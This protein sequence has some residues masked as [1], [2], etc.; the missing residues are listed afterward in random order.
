VLIF[1]IGIIQMTKIQLPTKTVGESITEYVN[2]KGNLSTTEKGRRFLF[3]IRENLIAE[4]SDD[5]EVWLD[6]Y[7]DGGYDLIVFAAG[8]FW[9]I[10]AKYQTSH[11]LESAKAFCNDAQR[12]RS[13]LNGKEQN[14]PT[15]AHALV[16]RV[17]SEG[18]DTAQTHLSAIYITD[19]SFT[20]YQAGILT[21]QTHNHPYIQFLDL[22]G[23]TKYLLQVTDSPSMIEYPLS[24]V[25]QPTVLGSV[26]ICVVPLVDLASFA[27]RVGIQLFAANIRAYLKRTSINKDLAATLRSK[28]DDFL[29]FNNGI[30]MIAA[31]FKVIPNPWQVRVT[32]AQVVNGCQTV[33]EI[34]NAWLSL[35][36]NKQNKNDLS[37]SV[38]VKVVKT[39]EKELIRQISRFTNRQNAVRTRDFLAM[40]DE[41]RALHKGMGKIGYYYEITRG[42]AAI[43]DQRKRSS[44]K[45]NDGYR[46]LDRKPGRFP[47]IRAFDSQQCFL[48]AYLDRP[49][50]AREKLGQLN[51]LEPEYE[52]AFRG[53]YS[54][55]PLAHLLPFLIHEAAGFHDYGSSGQGW[56][57][58]ARLWFVA[59][60]YR[61]IVTLLAEVDDRYKMEDPYLREPGVIS[62]AVAEIMT[63]QEIGEPL[64][65]LADEIAISFNALYKTTSGEN[66]HEKNSYRKDEHH[67]NLRL[68]DA[69]H[70]IVVDHV[71]KRGVYVIQNK[72]KAIVNAN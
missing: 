65:S 68:L 19:S 6:G 56:K 17:R 34:K 20:D 27:N 55:E 3:W 67:T 46:Y 44:Y 12:L 8:Q 39:Q 63:H 64:L 42:Q 5:Y 52:G 23:I 28:S 69:L 31:D 10:Q 66:Y 72:I 11:S 58:H 21:E 13:V 41:Q 2:L 59:I 32:N 22:V 4:C 47:L 18:I 35:K 24:T 15:L 61:M 33:N 53:V 29:L 36:D 43:L 25:A 49:G 9:A 1:S 51:P 48:A 45:P 60:F 62:T 7:Q 57:S 16:E 71:R 14:I 40:D 30:T 54:D 38:L 50:L 70:Q 37:G 26:C